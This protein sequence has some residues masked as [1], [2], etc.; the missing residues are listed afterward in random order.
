VQ[1]GKKTG[2]V[3]EL[4][5]KG[6]PLSF[7]DCLN[8]EDVQRYSPTELLDEDTVD[9]GIAAE[10]AGNVMGIA[11]KTNAAQMVQAVEFLF[12]VLGGMLW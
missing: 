10:G 8:N 6:L 11:V 12:H 1:R 2:E 5:E 9:I 4:S 3:G 7:P